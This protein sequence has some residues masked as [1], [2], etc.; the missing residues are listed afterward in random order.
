MR[1]LHP[2]HALLDPEDPPREVA[3]LENVARRAL[4]REVFVDGSE[5]GALGL[6]HHAVV[7]RIGNGS[8]RGDGEQPRAPTAPQ[9]AIHR[10]MMDQRGPAAPAGGESLR[11]HLDHAVELGAIQGAVRIGAPHQCEELLRRPVLAGG[12]G[13]DLLGQHVE[14]LFP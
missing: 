3:K 9:P 5:E 10:V 12:L 6:E 11:Q 4:D 8:A 13:H 14:R 7:G 1:V 2:H